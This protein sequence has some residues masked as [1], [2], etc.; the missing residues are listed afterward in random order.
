M[1]GLA[2]QGDVEAGDLGLL[3]D[4][5]ADGGIQP[6]E[7]GKGDD[8]AIEDGRQNSLDLGH[9]LARIAF[10]KALGA[11]DAADA[12]VT[13]GAGNEANDQGAGGIDEA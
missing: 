1:D 13:R 7:D 3:V 4:A 8:A 5:Q 9:H 11:D 6:L 12:S 10:H 2:V